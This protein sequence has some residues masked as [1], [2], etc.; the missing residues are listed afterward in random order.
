MKKVRELLLSPL[1]LA[2][3]QILLTVAIAAGAVFYTYANVIV[4]RL[5]KIVL[6][7]L[8]FVLCCGGLFLLAYLQ[9][10]PEASALSLLLPFLIG[11]AAFSALF[12]GLQ[13]ILNLFVNRTVSCLVGI[14]VALAFNLACVVAQ[15]LF[16]FKRNKKALLWLTVIPVVV[17]YVATLLL[18]L[19]SLPH[20]WAFKSF[21]KDKQT[22]A[23]AEAES[24]LV[25]EEDRKAGL[26]FMT[27]HL[28]GE[29][30]SPAFDF[31]LGGKSFRDDL[32]AW[33][34][35][36]DFY[37]E[38]VTGDLSVE[39]TF[40]EGKSGLSV[41]LVA[42]YYNQ[43]ATVEWTVFISNDGENNSPQLSDLFALDFALDLDSPTLYFSGGSA[44][45][46]DDYALYSRRLG[47]GKMTFDTV[48]GRSSTLYL[49][50]FNLSSKRGGATLGIGW[51]GEW[52]ATFS[53]KDGTA[54]RIGQSALCGYLAPGESV[55][56][57]MIS[58]CLYS[59]SNP[60]KGFNI[61]RAD[62]KRGLPQGYTESSM[63]L[64]AGAEGQDDTSRANA[65]GTYAYME[66]LQQLGIADTLDYAWYD[67]AWYDTSGSGDWRTSVGDWKVDASKYPSGLGSISEYLDE[68]DVGM[69]LWYEPERV[70][71][72]SELCKTTLATEGSER[73][74]I[75][76]QN[77][78]ND[79]LWNMGDDAAREFMTDYIAT[80][81]LANGVSFYRQDFNIDPKAYWEY[82][83]RAY[84]DG[85]IGFAENHYVVGEYAFLDGL[86]R[87][88]PDLLIDNCASGGRRIE[89]E[90]CR[91]S[92]PLWRSDYQCKTEKTDLSEAAQYQQ[93]GLSM[94]L[95][96]SCVT[97][98]NAAS[99]YD[100]R[101]LLGSYVML[102]GDVLFNTPETYLS[103]VGD[104][105][106]IKRYFAQNYYPL[107]S[108]TTRS[109]V[110]AMQ[111]GSAEEGVILLYSRAGN[112]GKESLVMNGLSAKATY[113]LTTAEGQSVASEK[114]SELM[115]KGFSFRTEGKTAY[116]I[117]YKEA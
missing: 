24:Y 22:F 17:I 13:G 64:F 58:L 25:T 63:L 15:D 7:D 69:L 56:T 109:D 34:A 83:D 12:F 21:S 23:A 31:R 20:G 53:S 66:K 90:M 37:L 85:R 80:S 16:A 54:V 28:T 97:N 67:A 89:L 44:E 40:T 52:T 8:T 77:G 30:V 55:R 59:G 45:A 57:P 42:N 60:L 62:V 82:A 76:P 19:F 32:S 103:F 73:W 98:P 46:N 61:F 79:Y 3:A 38:S 1:F 110:V 71:A 99:E 114:G 117:L 72:Q 92:V 102:Y 2:V 43:T 96:Y 49:P 35:S 81:L 112:K 108:C 116:I 4:F 106:K 94:W 39:R 41:R 68:Q 65:Q 10:Q 51:A 75:A 29:S 9:K 104:Y 95:P 86:K 78:G 84:Y 6:I 105:G 36:T 74:L 5:W 111:Y 91:R 14:S 47:S 27:E 113:I 88:I 87:R 107:T 48:N 93:Y 50:F 18:S 100:M 11:A 115:S 70:P 101:S 33:N 26:A